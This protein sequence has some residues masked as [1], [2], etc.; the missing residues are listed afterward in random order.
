MTHLPDASDDTSH[1]QAL[2]EGKIPAWMVST[3][4]ATHQH[5][6]TALN[7][8]APWFAKACQEQPADARKLAREYEAYRHASSD[9]NA[10]F[11]ALPDLETF[12]RE[13]LTSAID[14][15][16]GLALD[17]TRTYLFNAGKAEAYQASMGADPFTAAQR[18][19]K[20]ATQSLLHCALQNFEAAEAEPGGLDGQTLKSVVLDSHQFLAH[21]PTGKPVQIAPQAFASL[22][23][24]LDIG[25]QYQALLAAVY[26]PDSGG[27]GAAVNETLG[28]AEQC[29]FRLELHRAY[30]SNMLDLLLYE[31]LLKLIRGDEVHY[32]ESPMRWAFLKLFDVSVTGALVIGVVPFPEL[33]L[34]YDITRL[35]Y[36]N[37]LVTYLPGAPVPLKVH[38][39]VLEVQVH[40]REQL[41]AMQIRHLQQGVPAR[42]SATF[43]EKLRDC[44]Q[45]VDWSR[46]QPAP[47]HQGEQ[48][49]RV[50]DPEAWVAVTLQPFNRSLLDE[51]VS[52]KRQRRMDDA[53]YHA[54][55]TAQEDQK[56]TEKRRAY[57]AQLAL[58]ALNLGAFVVP[59]LGQLMLGLSLIQL[60]YEVFE[61]IENWADGDREQALD[62]LMDIVENVALTAVAV[63]TGAADGTPAVEKIPVDMP[64]FIEELEPVVMPDGGSRLWLPDARPF[65]HDTVLP[66]GLQADEFGLY[67]HDGKAW[68]AIEG[69]TYSVTQAPGSTEYRLV[70]PSKA[71]SYEP[72]LRHNGAG[73]WL[74]PADRPE[75]WPELPLFRRAGHLGAHFDDETALRILRV[76]GTQEDVLRRALCDSQRLPAQLEDTLSRFKLYQALEQRPEL[77]EPNV[78]HSEFERHYRAL[79]TPR[80][81]GAEVIQSR[82]PQLPAP[83]TEELL[84]HASPSER[85]ELAHG[86]V[87]T[88]LAEEVRCLAQQV[89][90]N[91]AYEG[92]YLESVRNWDSDVL[93]L[94]TLEQLPGWSTETPIT[95]EQRQHSPAQVASIGASEVPATTLII[96]AR[97]G[98]VVMDSTRPDDLLSVHSSLPGALFEVLTAEQREALGVEDEQALR[99]RVQQAPLLPRAALRKVLGMQSVRPGFRSPMRLA[100][101]RLGYPL[102]GNRPRVASISRQTL[103][104]SIRQIGQYAPIPRPAEQTL[105]ALENRNLTRAQIDDMLSVLLEQR[106]QLQSRLADWRQL[107]ARMPHQPPDDF[108]RLMNAITQHWYDRAFLTAS[109]AVGPLR[110]ERLSLAQFPLELPEFFSASVTD[111]QLI[112]TS[113]ENYEG[114]NQHGPQ[115]H[116]L[117]RQFANLRSLEIS[118]NYRPE[119][120]P[121][122]LQFSLPMIAQRLP[123]LELLSLTNQNISLSSTDIDSLAGLTQLRRLDLSGNRFSEHYPP[124]FNELTLD[125]LGLDNMALDHW[126]EGVGFNT[127]TQ[128]HHIGLRNNHIRILPHFLRDNHINIAEHALVSM[129]GNPLFEDEVRRVMLSEDGRASRFEMDQPEDVR[130]RLAAQLAQRQQLRDAIDNY[131]NA[132]SSAAPVSQAVMAARTRIAAALN[133]FW[134]NQEIGLT[135]AALRLNDVDLE[136]FP[137]RLPAFFTAQVHNLALDRVS[138]S[139]AQFDA[140][141]SR[142][143]R[144]TRLTIDDYQHAEQ[145]L[146]SALLRLPGLTDI[147]LR[148]SGLLIDQQ[149]LDTLGGL[150]NLNSLDL[151]GNRMGTITHA[152]QALQTIRRLD[153]NS[154]ALDQWPAWVDGLLPLEML[155]LSDNQL[156]ELP[157]HI[158]ANLDNDFPISSILLFSNPLT[159]ETVMRA[160]ASSDSQRSYTFA[161]DLS[162][163]MSESSGE[164]GMG[165]HHH[166]PFLD[167]MADAPNVEDWLLAT[168]LENEALRDSWET[169]QGSGEAEHLL[170]LVGRL[171]NAAPYQNGKT[172][173]SFCQRVRKVL[174]SAVVNTQDLALFNL[175]AREA[176]VQDNG[177]Q[178]C[179][180]GAL[181]VFQNIEL[182]IANQRLQIDAADT[183]GNLYRELRRLYR[184]QA[185]DEV[186]Q[187]EAA[188]RDEAEVRLTYRRELN[189]PLELG[190]PND[191][192]RYAINANIDELAYAELEVQR[193]ELAE[194]FLNFAAAN[195]RWVQYL[196]QA[197]ADRFADIEHTYQTQVSE[198]PDQYP[199]RPLSSLAEEFQALER[200]RQ[201]RELRLIR[202]LTS[203]ADPDRK[204][205]SSTE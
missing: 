194:D 158:L 105:A 78:L 166:L 143:A 188:N 160:R 148:Q 79:P 88:R 113:P 201:T 99:R 81:P 89:R 193:R 154:M 59:G 144:V 141:L 23:R 153:L 155:D 25:G 136:H 107:A 180:D 133:E 65:A 140:L 16:F 157:E 192:L 44:L 168:D 189:A 150:P 10:L 76:S 26:Q 93:V 147:A 9:A 3:T 191:T 71:L 171:R 22:V 20:L 203:F 118:R 190:L 87:P 19:F 177:D 109:D 116:S 134:H 30:L 53:S 27:D 34:S 40:L 186:A 29:A 84:R 119:G 98:Y 5:M 58:G 24:E 175:Q 101:G 32:L 37:V 50:R 42:D 126:P 8:P 49:N 91:R 139:T 73:A 130:A 46:V 152:P 151:T 205:R 6:R 56:T 35:P 112:E 142:L 17:V 195:P 51:L 67:H 43:I 2:I 28:K 86:K 12:A 63:A 123:A 31:A 90:L 185:L 145:T 196:R 129:Q 7:T 36:K 111:L 13:Q 199:D 181:L 15:R 92:L 156:T 70:H 72:P 202:E 163:S 161:I 1:P 45:P 33:F 110:L 173:V 174:G 132:S 172:R 18:A 74:L 167:P 204:P 121:S 127:L 41:W 179:H 52:Q 75:Q 138:G 176:L 108:E 82:Y 83:L 77:A 66:A 124:R 4:P 21:L 69:N 38:S 96:S 60:S 64:S 62:Y 115:L 146:P 100:D 14:A 97:A 159:D 54:V 182:Y 149:V 120:T 61:G 165:G 95:V 48:T 103:L 102:G 106:N 162:D 197:Y 128:V 39:T 104:N 187:S 125:Y 184:L 80:V 170:A 47:T 137:R 198:L 178:T 135:R 85:A 122:A 55:S 117:T 114:W 94:H 68:L 169:L 164:G 183:E 131:V 200:N 57:F 11:K